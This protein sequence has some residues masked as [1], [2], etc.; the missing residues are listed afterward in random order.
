M[1]IVEVQHYKIY[2]ALVVQTHIYFT[3]LLTV[4]LSIILTIHQLNARNLL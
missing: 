3:A 1:Y 2:I 4:H